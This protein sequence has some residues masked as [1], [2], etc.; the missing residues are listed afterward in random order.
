MAKTVIIGCKLPHGI[1]LEHPLDP[2][3][4]VKL[5]GRHASP[6]IG[7]THSTTEVDADLWETWKAVHA[8]FAPLKAK[9]IFEA[10]SAGDASAIASELKDEKTGFEGM[11]QTAGGVK[12]AD[13]D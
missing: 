6:I 1:I 9:A 10:K 12:P 13:K 8:N 4:S 3:K 7:A 11:S 2:S 5:A